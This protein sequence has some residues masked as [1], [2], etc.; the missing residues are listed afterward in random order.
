MLTWLTWRLYELMFGVEITGGAL[1]FMRFIGF[2]EL[3]IELV[4]IA[5]LIIVAI[6]T[7]FE[8][9]VEKEKKDV[10]TIQPRR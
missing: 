2:V 5:I 9:K 4:I 1:D 10:K 8:S 7:Y 3:L 6:S